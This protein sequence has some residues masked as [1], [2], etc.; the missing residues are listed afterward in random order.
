MKR[1]A[2][3][4]AAL[5]YRV[6]ITAIAEE[7]GGG[8]LARLPQFGRLGI[9]GDGETPEEA[10]R[11]LEAAKRERFA[12]YLAEG[13]AIPEPETEEEDFSGRFVVRLP[14]F[15][16][17]ELVSTARR[18]EVSLN[19]YVVTLLTVNWRDDKIGGR[20]ERLESE[21]GR[22]RRWVGA[23]TYDTESGLPSIQKPTKQ[24]FADEYA[25]AA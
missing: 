23:I 4:Y 12:E 8:Y 20:L 24:Y 19:Q 1:N 7:E 9:V 15:L 25:T 22:L 11:E 21:L 14:K 2:D 6:E 3:Y 16:H 17:R 13:R 18:N 5:P 10:L